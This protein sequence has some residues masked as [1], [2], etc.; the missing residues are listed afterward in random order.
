[1]I[2]RRRPWRVSRSWEVLSGEGGTAERDAQ[3]CREDFCQI[4]R[5]ENGLS[6]AGEW[7]F[8]G[9]WYLKAFRGF[10]CR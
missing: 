9:E 10:S 7:L 2:S 6:I 3:C 1:M 5:R 8:Q 4:H